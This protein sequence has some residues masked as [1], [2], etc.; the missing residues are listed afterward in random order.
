[1][2]NYAVLSEASVLASKIALAFSMQQGSR[3]LDFHERLF[4][5]KG[6]LGAAVAIDTA[7]SLGADKAK[8]IID[9]D[10]DQVT[11]ALIAS[12]R[13]GSSLGLNATPSYIIGN[14]GFQGYLNTAAKRIAIANIRA[15]E[16]TSC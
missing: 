15:C 12:S 6:Q 13:L 4:K 2:I 1:M 14:E 7:V 3:Y 8:L 9:A 11:Q 16:K 5:R 10:S